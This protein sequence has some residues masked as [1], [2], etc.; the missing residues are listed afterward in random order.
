MFLLN[1]F[2]L[3]KIFRNVNKV[4]LHISANQNNYC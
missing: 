2:E 3:I 4:S 1:L